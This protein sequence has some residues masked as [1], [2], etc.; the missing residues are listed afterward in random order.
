MLLF[1]NVKCFF[2]CFYFWISMAR[3]FLF[4]V[5]LMISDQLMLTLELKRF[6]CSL[7]STKLTVRDA[8]R[9]QRM[10][11]VLWVF[12]SWRMVLAQRLHCAEMKSWV[13][14]TFC[15]GEPGFLLVTLADFTVKLQ[16]VYEEPCLAGICT[17][18]RL[19][20]VS[21]EKCLCPLTQ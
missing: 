6:Y 13:C 3:N 16:F 15:L 21:N 8:L 5:L 7:F 19:C 10:I 2:F 11:Y 14:A 20:W 9:A 18:T 17:V 1:C 4:S 12:A